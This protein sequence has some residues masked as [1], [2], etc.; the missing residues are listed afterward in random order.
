MTIVFEVYSDKE[1]DRGLVSRYWAQD[2]EGK[3]VEKVSDL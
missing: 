2:E 1:I 3:F